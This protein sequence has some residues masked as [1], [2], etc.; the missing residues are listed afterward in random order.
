MDYESLI[1]ILAESDTATEVAWIWFYGQ[2]LEVVSLLA[3]MILLGW[4]FLKFM[5]M[6]QSA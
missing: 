5:K 4:G 1:K 2:A 6:M 3:F